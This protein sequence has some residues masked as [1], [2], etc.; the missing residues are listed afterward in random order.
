MDQGC[1]RPRVYSLPSAPDPS[2]TC[3][4][5]LHH[6]NEV[7]RLAEGGR[8][9]VLILE[10]KHTDPGVSEARGQLSTVGTEGQ[11]GLAGPE[12]LWPLGITS[13]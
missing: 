8:V 3:H 11:F 5:V 9:V 13:G 1:S 6:G 12:G 2:C 4:D 10:G 7:G